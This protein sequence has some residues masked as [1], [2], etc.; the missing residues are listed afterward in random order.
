MSD[1]LI[2]IMS[3]EEDIEN[4]AN[5]EDAAEKLVIVIACEVLAEPAVCEEG[6]EL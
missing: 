3:E 2:A 4:D 1:A 6:Q 5:D